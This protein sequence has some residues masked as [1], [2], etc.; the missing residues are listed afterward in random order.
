MTFYEEL[1]AAVRGVRRRY[2]ALDRGQIAPIRRC[3]TADDVALEAAYWRVGGPVAHEQSYL[4]H[5]VLLFPTAPHAGPSARAFSLGRFLRK[6]LGDETGAALRFRRVLA[7]RDRD[8]LSHRLRSVL[9][10][11][12]AD[13][14]AVDW[15]VVGVDVLWFFGERDLVRRRWAQD[16]YAP[17]ASRTPD[18]TH[19]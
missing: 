12:C 7:C 8:E 5:V 4:P 14:S 9:R 19:V 18:I 6:Q 13:R 17:L 11:A 15:G 2:D 10:L 3:R 16:F 1:Q